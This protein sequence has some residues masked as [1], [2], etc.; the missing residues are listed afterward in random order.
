MPRAKIP[1]TVL[2]SDGRPFAGAAVTVRK[3]SDASLATIYSAETGGG[4][5]AN[6]LT[7]DAFGRVGGWVDRN[8]YDC[9]VTGSGLTTFTEPLDAAPAGDDTADHVWLDLVN[10]HLTGTYASRPTATAALNGVRFF[11]TDKLMEWQCVSAAWVLV[12]TLPLVSA[13][14]PS[15]GIVGQRWNYD[16]GDGVWEFVADAGGWMFAGG[17]QMISEVDTDQARDNATYGDLATVGPDITCPFAGVYIVG[18]GAG[19][20]YT[21]G[22]QASFM[23]F[24][25]A[26]TAATDADGAAN[27]NDSAGQI[28]GSPVYRERKK[29]LAAGDLLRAKY[30][31]QGI[32]TT[33]SWSRRWMTLKP[34]SLTL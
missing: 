6:P 16:H 17:P 14:K 28:G 11:A 9:I 25:V 24:A 31:N 26:A 23:S 32:G 13:S 15:G 30:R 34:I 29:T 3:R 20:V 8:A 10:A 22:A 27:Q 2:G 18:V 21:S 12:N 19:F 7:S 4:T 1:V 5:L 33:S